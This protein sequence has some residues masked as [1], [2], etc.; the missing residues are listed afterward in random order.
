VVS[1]V[2]I[3]DLEPA[4]FGSG[5]KEAPLLADVVNVLDELFFTGT[6]G[7]SI[8]SSLHEGRFVLVAQGFAGWYSTMAASMTDSARRAPNGNPNI[9][10]NPATLG[11]G[12]DMEPRAQ[13]WSAFRHV[14]VGF[15]AANLDYQLS[16]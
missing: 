12:R 8:L 10:W 6:P 2:L 9:S 14:V 1:L 7:H 15:D 13:F 16:K 5:C 3:D 11:P 4:R